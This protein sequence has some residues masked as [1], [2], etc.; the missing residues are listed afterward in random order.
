MLAWCCWLMLVWMVLMSVA[1]CRLTNRRPP[2]KLH[3]LITTAGSSPRELFIRRWRQA[4]NLEPPNG[5]EWAPRRVRDTISHGQVRRGFACLCLTPPP[6]LS[7]V[8][9]WPQFTPFNA[10]LTSPFS[11]F[12]CLSFW[13]SAFFSGKS[14]GSPFCAF[15]AIL[16]FP[17]FCP[18]HNICMLLLAAT[19]H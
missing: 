13:L 4:F 18:A 1:A 10:Q 11:G 12:Q 16:S 15:A 8:F 5:K 9:A 3:F 6:F 14:I 17:P 19:P 2:R 7:L